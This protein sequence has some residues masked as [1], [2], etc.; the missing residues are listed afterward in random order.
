MAMAQAYPFSQK[1]HRGSGL[2]TIVDF[3]E[4]G[5]RIH[6]ILSTGQ[7][8]QITSLHY[9]DQ[10]KLWR[11]GKYLTYDPNTAKTIKEKR[12]IKQKRK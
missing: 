12:G 7:S 6:M 10:N 11:N 9:S 3:S 1:A 2:R 8:G 5:E 4:P